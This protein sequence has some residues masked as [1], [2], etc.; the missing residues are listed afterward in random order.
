MGLLSLPAELRLRIYD[1]LPDLQGTGNTITIVSG[2]VLTPHI[3]RTNK[4]LRQETLSLYARNARFAIYLT[5]SSGPDRLLSSAMTSWLNDLAGAGLARMS[6]LFLSRN[7]EMSKPTRGQGHSGFYLKLDAGKDG[8]A[9]SASSW[10]ST[11][12]TWPIANN[13][14][15]MRLKSAEFLQQMVISRLEGIDHDEGNATIGLGFAPNDL[16]FV[17]GAMDIVARHPFSAYDG[18]LGGDSEQ[19]KRSEFERMERELMLLADQ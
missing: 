6:E 3:S 2:R 12:G 13:M 1:F 14:K 16:K 9:T 10:K 11:I 19:R 18:D 5:A 17:I 7:W 8:P 15:G 4:L